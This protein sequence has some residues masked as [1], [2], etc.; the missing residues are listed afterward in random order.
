MP[1]IPCWKEFY[2]IRIYLNLRDCAWWF[3]RNTKQVEAE[4]HWQELLGTVEPM[5]VWDVGSNVGV[6]ALLAAKMGHQ[7]VAFD[8]STCAIN[9]MLKSARYNRLKI[10]HNCR[11]FSTKDFT[12]T[13]PK[14]ADT[15]NKPIMGS[16]FASITFLEAANRHGVPNFIKMDIEHGEVEFLQSELFH[17]WIKQHDITL[18][19]EVHSEDY[20]K[21]VWPDVP[22]RM[23]YGRHVLFNPKGL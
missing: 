3:S 12:Y 2:G 16:G 6:F 18:L 1:P 20:M 11:A 22:W 23:L 17:E 9:L 13:P 14:T 15:C 5:R 4:E 8:I 7:V 10:E 19:M 21:F